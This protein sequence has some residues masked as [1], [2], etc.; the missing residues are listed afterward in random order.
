MFFVVH[1]ELLLYK[2][3]R[4]F[5]N[6]FFL[7]SIPDCTGS[8]HLEKQSYLSQISRERSDSVEMIDVENNKGA[9]LDD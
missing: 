4:V 6:Q 1:I 3:T 2:R 7:R 5:N 9:K 8:L